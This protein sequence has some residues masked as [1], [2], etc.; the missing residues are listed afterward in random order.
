MKKKMLSF[1]CLS[2]MTLMLLACGNSST[3]SDNSASVNSETSMNNAETDKCPNSLNNDESIS[4]E[5]VSDNISDKENEVSKDDNQEAEKTEESSEKKVISLEA[6]I[7]IN[8]QTVAL[9]D[10][11]YVLSEKLG[12][13]DYYEEADSCLGA[14]KDRVYGYGKVT[15]KTMPDGDKDGVNLID[16][17]E[18]GV[19][20]SGIIVGSS[21]K[22]DVIAV[23]GNLT[24]GSDFLEYRASNGSIFFELEGNVVKFVEI[25]KG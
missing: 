10:D 25:Y 20:A 15:I 2:A 3:V 14:G 24:E 8:G 18:G 1:L 6:E 4:E 5:K 12:A 22:E 17:E 21:T 9:G 16:I 11:M 13:T 23:Y 7:Y 19:L